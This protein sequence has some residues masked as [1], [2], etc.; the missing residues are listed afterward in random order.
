MMKD[1]KPRLYKIT[2]AAALNYGSEFS[3]LNKSNSQKF[4]TPQ[5]C[6]LRSL[7]GFIKLAHQRNTAVRNK[8]QIPRITDEIKEYQKKKKWK[9]HLWRM[10]KDRFPKHLWNTP[11]RAQIPGR[12]KYR[13]HLLRFIVISHKVS[14]EVVH[15]VDQSKQDTRKT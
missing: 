2:Y 5:M 1:T 15:D 11:R 10:D 14:H 8:F 7:L 12:L 6:F 9:I 4:E 3:I 13:E